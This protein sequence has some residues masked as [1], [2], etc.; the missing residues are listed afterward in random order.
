M[1]K[2]QF[3]KT[4]PD[5]II[6]TKAYP[7]DTGFDLT[8]LDK[9]KEINDCAVT[10]FDTGIIVIPPEGFYTELVARSSIIKTGYILANGI[11]ILDAGY[12]ASIKVPLMRLCERPGEIKLPNKIVQLVIRRLHEFEFEEVTFFNDTERGEGG[13]GSSDNKSL[14][15]KGE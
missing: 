11:G 12:R 10:L 6:P 15:L 3:I 4:R 2:I 13:F 8:I 14:T 7:N 5:A 1:N 9:F